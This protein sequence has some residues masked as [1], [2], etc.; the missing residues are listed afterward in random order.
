MGFFF[1]FCLFGAVEVL[2]ADETVNKFEV[3]IEGG[4]MTVR[5]LWGREEEPLLF[6]YLN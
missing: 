6:Y 1:F 3:G 2:G 5:K 4:H